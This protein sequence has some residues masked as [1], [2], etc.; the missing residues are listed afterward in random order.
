MSKTLINKVIQYIEDNDVDDNKVKIY[1][2]DIVNK[3]KPTIRTISNRYSLIKKAIR[4]NFDGFSPEFLKSIKPDDSIIKQ[5]L[6]E[7]MEKRS[8]KSIFTFTEKM[9]N[10]ILDLKESD[11]IY[12][13]GI[14]LQFI[15]GR[16][17]SEIYQH[18]NDHNKI[19]V[20]RIKNKPELVKFSTLHKKNNDKSEI[21]ELIPN[22]LDSNEFKS[23]YN[24]INNELNIS[25]QDYINRI[26]MKV[27]KMFSKISNMSSHKLR[28]MYARYMFE[29][30]NK[31]EQNINGYI[32]KILNHGSPESSLSY[33]N[34]NYIPTKQEA[35]EK[36]IKKKI[37]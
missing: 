2:D 29:T 6:S 25:T 3:D 1:I 11:D 18:I 34:Y 14:Y 37:L 26:N 27:K 5:I 20:D 15:S 32:T 13:N 9:V 33:S 12:D 23:M 22:T 8:S 4:E 10:D 36:R 17:A 19:K 35:P 24:K 28:G 7:D 21:I 30:N 16:R 31:E